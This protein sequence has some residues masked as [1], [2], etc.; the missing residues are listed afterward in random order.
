[1]NTINVLVHKADIPL[2]DNESLSSF[3]SKLSSSGIDYISKKLKLKTNTQDYQ[4]RDSAYS[5]EIFYSKAVFSVWRAKKGEKEQKYYSLDYTR[6]DNGDF[7]FNN[8]KEVEIKREFQE[9]KKD[10]EGNVVK[11][12]GTWEEVSKPYPNEHASRQKPP[13]YK[14]YARIHPKGFPAGVDAILGIKIVGGKRKSEI[15]SIRFKASM[16]TPE[17]ARKWLKDHNFKTNLEVSSK[18][19]KDVKKEIEFDDIWTAKKSFWE[20]IPF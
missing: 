16:W 10:E 11:A 5:F 8:L 12:E 6:K 15:Q 14:E 20:G 1:M 17:K 18:P 3:T 9:V 19:K 4:K 2:R 13:N 7:Q